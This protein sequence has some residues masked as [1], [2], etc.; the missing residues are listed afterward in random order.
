MSLNDFNE[1]LSSGENETKEL[2]RNATLAGLN[3]IKLLWGK[4]RVSNARLT[5]YEMPKFGK[6]RVGDPTS[7]DI[8]LDVK[9]VRGMLNFYL[10]RSGRAWAYVIDTPHNRK[11]MESSFRSGW[12]RIVDPAIREQVLQ[13]AKANG[14]KTEKDVEENYEIKKTPREIRAEADAAK[15]NSEKGDLEKKI[16]ELQEQ[17]RKMQTPSQKK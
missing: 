8:D 14:I 7:V 12:Y 4:A 6:R 2:F 1:E 10:D 17:V 9:F 13:A 11:V 3:I 15:A 16:A 5:G